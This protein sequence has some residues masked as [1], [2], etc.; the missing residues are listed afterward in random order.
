MTK[1]RDISDALVSY[2]GDKGTNPGTDPGTDPG[3]G[4]STPGSGSK[5]TPSDNNAE[6]EENRTSKKVTDSKG[7][8]Y[9]AIVSMNST[10]PYSKNKKTL[11][12][13]L[14][15]TCTVI[16]SDGNPTGITVK[17]MKATKPKGGYT[18]VTIVLK[19][20][21]KD[22]RKA[23]KTINKQLKKLKIQVIGQS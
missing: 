6:E 22:E 9:T 16:D 23:V 17:S 15:V 21:D 18:K 13:S 7:Y 20:S 12:N 1:V 19:G 5:D 3:K 8:G 4:G 11:A 2:S 14:N 10:V